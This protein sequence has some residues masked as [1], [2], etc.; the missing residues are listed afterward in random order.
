[1]LI[2]ITL[3]GCGKSSPGYDIY[4]YNDVLLVFIRMDDTS[5][6]VDAKLDDQKLKVNIASNEEMFE[7]VISLR[8][9]LIISLVEK[10]ETVTVEGIN[11]INKYGVV[12]LKVSSPI[13]RPVSMSISWTGL[14]GRNNRKKGSHSN[15]G[16]FRIDDKLIAYTLL[17]DFKKSSWEVSNFG[18]NIRHETKTSVDNVMN[19]DV[20]DRF[21][22]ID[23]DDPDIPVHNLSLPLTDLTSDENVEVK[24]KKKVGNHL[25]IIRMNIISMLDS[26]ATV[27]S[28]DSDPS[29]NSSIIDR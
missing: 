12:H 23:V 13:P 8:K 15:N 24:E 16:A 22:N 28:D 25:Y 19:D 9:K 1:M 20:G 11:R 3:V 2:L 29:D 5:K 17:P 4:R 14:K 26:Q 7:Q 27:V 10:D 21:L 18:I 6:I